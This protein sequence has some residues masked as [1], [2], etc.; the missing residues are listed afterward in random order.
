MGGVNFSCFFIFILLRFCTIEGIPPWVTGGCG[1]LA[2]NPDVRKSGLHICPH[3]LPFFPLAGSLEKW[4][5]TKMARATQPTE[6]QYRSSET[7]GWRH[8]G[9]VHL[10]LQSMVWGTLSFTQQIVWCQKHEGTAIPYSFSKGRRLLSTHN[11]VCLTEIRVY[12]ICV[13]VFDPRENLSV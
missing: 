1:M 13:W 3:S 6:P 8:G 7:Y 10:Y 5:T 2:T 9:Y 11:L 12:C 4:G